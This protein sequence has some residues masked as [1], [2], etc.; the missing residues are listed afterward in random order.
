MVTLG[1]IFSSKVILSQLLLSYIV[2]ILKIEQHL[3]RS[4]SSSVNSL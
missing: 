4:S 2:L 3:D 1:T